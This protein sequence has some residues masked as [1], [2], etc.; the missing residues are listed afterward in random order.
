MKILVFLEQRQN[1][2]RPAAL[3]ALAAA[4]KIES[5]L[6]NI[7]AVVVG[8][9][10]VGAAEQTKGFGASKVYAVEHAELAAY[11]PLKYCDAIESAV[12]ESSPDLVLFSASPMG[13]DLSPRL[14]ARF[15]SGILSDVTSIQ[16]SGDKVTAKKP[17]YAGKIIANV[18]L[19]LS[20]KPGIISVRPNTFA[21]NDQLGGESSVSSVTAELK[22]TPLVT[23]SIKAGSSDKADL[24]EAQIVISGGRSLGSKENF[25][26]LDS[27]ANVLGATV[28]AS[29]AAVLDG[30]ADHSMQV[31]QTGKTVNPKLYISF[32]I[33]GQIQHLAGMRTSK[34]IVA[35]NTNPDAPI[36]SV[37]D[38][39]IVGDMFEALPIM[40][41]KF[42]ELLV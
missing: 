12:K 22:D 36:F 21:A 7:E 23:K 31:G 34:C 18:E 37:A 40:E 16:A 24:T 28:G 35:V 42:K 30:F 29:R 39:G 38:Y 27:L 26:K 6:S 8:E 9:S 41:Q 10:V 1:S 13:R 14:A 5:D 15:G 33:S 11:N 2:I 32:G 4:H 3:E 17:M 20:E 25:A 19:S